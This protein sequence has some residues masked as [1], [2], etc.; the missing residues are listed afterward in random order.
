MSSKLSLTRTVGGRSGRAAARRCLLL[1]LLAMAVGIT[2]SSQAVR[3]DVDYNGVV[4]IDDAT[5]LIDY[6]LD[7]E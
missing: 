7:H 1:L 2:A 6:L 3:G 4:N 5:T